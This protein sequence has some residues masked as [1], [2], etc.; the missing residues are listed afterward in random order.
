M[1]NVILLA[2]TALHDLASSAAETELSTVNATLGR[3]ASI[4]HQ[5]FH[6]LGLLAQP[7]GIRRRRVEE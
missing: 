4:R 2:D 5:F 3:V 1:A 7:L 6:A